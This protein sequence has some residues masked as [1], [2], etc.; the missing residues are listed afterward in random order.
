[1][2][3]AE[4]MRGYRALCLYMGWPLEDPEFISTPPPAPPPEPRGEPIANP[5]WATDPETG[6]RYLERFELLV[7]SPSTPA[8]G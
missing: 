2:L 8:S 5:V 7:T 3:S 4:Q 6:L 1:M